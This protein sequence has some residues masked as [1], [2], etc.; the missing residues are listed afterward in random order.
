M[1]NSSK[2]NS[3]KFSWKRK[4]NAEEQRSQFIV[5]TMTVKLFEEYCKTNDIDLYWSTWDME[6]SLNYSSINI[7]KN[8]QHMPSVQDF[9]KNISDDFLKEIRTRDDWQTKRDG[10]CGYVFHKQWSEHFIN[11][12]E[13]KRD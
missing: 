8:F 11:R 5:F 12:L 4:I 10:H 7:F 6:D 9:I 3:Q 13:T 2:K 1:P